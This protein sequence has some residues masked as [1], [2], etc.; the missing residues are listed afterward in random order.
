M[1]VII[2]SDESLTNPL[3][4]TPIFLPRFDVSVTSDLVGRFS[5]RT[6]QAQNLANDTA[7]SSWPAYQGDNLT[8]TQATSSRRPVY[9]LSGINGKAAV[10]F[11]AANTHCMF[12]GNFGTKVETPM[13]FCVVLNP[14]TGGSNPVVV[15]GGTSTEFVT[16]Y[17]NTTTLP[18]RVIMS[19]GSTSAIDINTAT[20]SS[21]ASTPQIICARVGG[22]NSAI[23]ISDLAPKVTGTT[24]TSAQ[25]PLAK[26]A[27]F[28]VGATRGVAS[29]TFDGLISEA[30]LYR[31]ALTNAEVETLLTELGAHYG[32]TIGA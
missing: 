31:K 7:I 6:F 30:M 9:K 19:M 14:G 24:T 16:M 21:A 26:L 3:P 25:T 1:A 20:N 2:R 28:A 13:T 12:S 18:G 10:Q 5:A 22:E 23:W 8:L 15:G 4:D 11:T 27:S 29:A 17:R 32:I